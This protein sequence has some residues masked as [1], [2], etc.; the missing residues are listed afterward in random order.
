[1]KLYVQSIKR[2]VSWHSARN[3]YISEFMHCNLF[4]LALQASQFL[5]SVQLKDTKYI[6][7]L[8]SVL[9]LRSTLIAEFVRISSLFTAQTL[10]NV[11]ELAQGANTP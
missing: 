3:T 8:N 10:K 9:R 5:I 11:I 6:H 2:N 7:L 1:M 4:R